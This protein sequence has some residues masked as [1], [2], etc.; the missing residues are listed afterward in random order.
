M[1]FSGMWSSPEVSG[2]RPPPCKDCSFTMIDE[3]YA[4]MFGGTQPGP[5][6]TNDM[7]MLDVIKMVCL[8]RLVFPAAINKHLGSEI[9]CCRILQIV[10]HLCKCNKPALF[11]I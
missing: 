7:Y 9:L 4:V 3:R 11:L 6:A 5:K 2:T 8:Q 10:V 1:A